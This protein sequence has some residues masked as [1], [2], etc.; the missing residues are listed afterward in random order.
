VKFIKQLAR[1]R[2]VDGLIEYLSKTRSVYYNPD[3]NAGRYDAVKALGKI[4]DPKSLEILCSTI[5][6]YSVHYEVP[7]IYV[8]GGN[9]GASPT[10]WSRYYLCK[11]ATKVLVDIGDPKVIDDLKAILDDI[12]SRLN[13]VLQKKELTQREKNQRDY[14]KKY[15]K[16]IINAISR[17]SP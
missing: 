17:L 10:D 2:D 3:V 7:S 12:D 4:K 15:K 16:P 9:I 5:N 8:P 1:N 11:A 13:E 6:V 14:Y